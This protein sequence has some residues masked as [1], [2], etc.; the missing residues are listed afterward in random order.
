MTCIN[1]FFRF[2]P[3]Q[4]IGLSCE[5]ETCFQGKETMHLRVVSTVR[6]LDISSPAVTRFAEPPA[7]HIR[8]PPDFFYP[9]MA[10]E[11]SSSISVYK[12]PWLV[13]LTTPI[14]IILMVFMPHVFV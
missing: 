8:L 10:T 12:K 4:D 2:Y 14:C 6:F 11:G 7:I 5:T 13:I 1:S 3:V 9:F